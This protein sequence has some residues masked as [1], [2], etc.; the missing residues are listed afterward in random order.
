MATFYTPADPNLIGSQA[1]HFLQTGI[2]LLAQAAIA[3]GISEEPVRRYLSQHTLLFDAVVRILNQTFQLYEPAPLAA[4]SIGDLAGTTRTATSEPEPDYDTTHDP[5]HGIYNPY[6]IE[7][8]RQLDYIAAMRN[9]GFAVPNVFSNAENDTGFSNTQ[10]H[11][12]DR[13]NASG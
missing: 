3:T 4:M 7:K 5:A 11:D 13:R 6:R 8:T 10:R 1:F 2:N 9:G 12:H